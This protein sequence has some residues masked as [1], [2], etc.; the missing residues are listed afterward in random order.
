MTDLARRSRRAAHSIGRARRRRQADVVHSGHRRAWRS[1]LA[2]GAGTAGRPGAGGRR[3]DGSVAVTDGG[4]APPAGAVLNASGYVTARRRATVSSKVTG[5]V[6][7]VLIE[8]GQ[9]VK[10]GQMLA[11]LDDSRRGRRWSSPRRSSPRRARAS[12][13]TKRS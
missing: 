1:A 5:K 4:P 11:H 9:P 12:P 2:G 13:R 6:I 3:Q 10:E 8:E 7:D